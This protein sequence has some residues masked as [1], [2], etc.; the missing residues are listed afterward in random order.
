MNVLMK[1]LHNSRAIV[2]TDPLQFLVRF[3]FNRIIS[4]HIPKIVF[5]PTNHF[6]SQLKQTYITCGR[7]LNYVFGY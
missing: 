2:P 3:Y 5:G 7:D 1:S 4:I 6:I